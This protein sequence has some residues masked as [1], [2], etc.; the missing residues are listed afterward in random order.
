MNLFEFCETFKVSL[1]KARKMDKAGVLRLDH[2][3]SEAAQAIRHWLSNGQPLTAAMLCEL[4][5]QPGILL[6]LGKYADKARLELAALGDAR[7]EA[8]PKLVAAHIADAARGDRD[9]VLVLVDWIKG[10]LPARPVGHSWIAARLLMGLPA[11]VRKFDIPRV[12]RAL[13]QCRKRPEFA[14]YW[15][16]EARGAKTFTHYAKPKKGLAKFDL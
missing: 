12:P 3:T 9:A 2:N 4:I 13:L 8:A 10:I 1:A 5:E 11:N 6:D 14:G 16:I 15:A 7:K